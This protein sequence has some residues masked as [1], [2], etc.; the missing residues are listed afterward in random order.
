MRPQ[1]RAALIA[2][3]C[4]LTAACGST[5]A[6]PVTSESLA[7]VTGTKI[8]GEASSP[9]PASDMDETSDPDTAMSEPQV[10]E[11]AD[12]EPTTLSTST[13]VPESPTAT[14]TP[15]LDV[16]PRSVTRQNVTSLDGAIAVAVRPGTNQV[17]IGRQTGEVH[18]LTPQGD[19]WGTA[20]EPVFSLVDRTIANKERGLL[21]FTFSPDGAF[22]YVAWTDRSNDA[23]VLTEYAVNESGIDASSERV[24]LVVDQPFRNHNGGNVAFG[25]DGYLYYGLGDG[26]SGG[27]PLGHGQNTNTLLGSIVRIDPTARDAGA[28]GI[29]PDNPFVNGGGAPEIFIVGA[30]NPWRFS[31]DQATGDLWI[32]DVG[33]DQFEEIN[34]FNAADGGGLGAN[35]GWNYREG[36]VAYRENSPKPVSAAGPFTDPLF[37]YP[38]EEGRCSVTGGMVYRGE[39]LPQ[40]HGAYIYGDFCSGEVFALS[41]DGATNIRLAVSVQRNTLASFGSDPTGEIWILTL[42]GDVVQ[43]I[44]ER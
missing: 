44:P 19:R 18:E 8:P 41:A 15:V 24:V 34:R 6:S 31:F 40:L 37:A 29:P 28:Y 10:I 36:F 38:H 26:G 16:D 2:A 43:L 9:T 4:V 3:A 1:A 30:R 25:P 21:G 23:N 27:D 7:T 11:T 39:A 14:A 35:L 20:Q 5:N 22:M 12:P 17:F 32:A 42:S 13:V 33:Q